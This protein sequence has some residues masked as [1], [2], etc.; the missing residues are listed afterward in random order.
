MN[1][2]PPRSEPG[3]TP[4][5][6]PLLRSLLQAAREDVPSRDELA[7]VGRGLPLRSARP[8]GGPRRV[9][10][11]LAT[12][13]AVCAV[14]AVAAAVALV[15]RPAPRPAET[16]VLARASADWP[17]PAPSAPSPP[18]VPSAEPAPPTDASP[19]RPASASRSSGVRHPA[20]VVPTP[21][22]AEPHGAPSASPASPAA[23]AADGAASKSEA[24]LLDRAAIVLDRNPAEAL[25]LADEHLAGFP[26]GE[27]AEARE[28]IAVEALRELGRV[29]EARARGAR[30][31]KQYPSSARRPLV[32]AI[33]AR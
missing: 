21:A 11:G 17:S 31:L 1:D 24:D 5:P 4:P 18:V 13:A 3:P 16:T 15:K 30:F 23:P 14:L 7:E 2:Q 12:P 29:D 9:S 25:R 32:E 10:R 6:S 20:V 26:T 28:V 8:R 22:S 33:I 19:Q 27:L